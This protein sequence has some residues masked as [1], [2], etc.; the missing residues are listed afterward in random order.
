MQGPAA[1]HKTPAKY[2][3]KGGGACIGFERA[4]VPFVSHENAAAKLFET[5]EKPVSTSDFF[6][7]TSDFFGWSS[8]FLCWSPGKPNFPSGEVSFSSGKLSFPPGKPCFSSTKPLFPPSKPPISPSKTTRT[9]GK[10]SP[11]LGILTPKRDSIAQVPLP[12][13]RSKGGRPVWVAKVSQ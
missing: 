6:M 7:W 9:G 2:K 5:F 8:G 4:H 12:K 1:E 11:K 10:T 3:P 13:N